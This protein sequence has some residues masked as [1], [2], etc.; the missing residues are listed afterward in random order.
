M[1]FLES[2]ED[3]GIVREIGL[4]QVLGAPL[5]LKR[6]LMLGVGSVATVQRRLQRLKRRGVVLE[7]RSDDDRR[8]IELTLSPSCMRTFGKYEA[9]LAES[10]TDPAEGKPQRRALGRHLCVLC[11]GEPSCREL[12]KRASGGA[13][14]D[15]GGARSPQAMLEFFRP[16]FEEARAAGKTI[17]IVGNMTWSQRKM[18]FDTLME[19]EARVDPLLRQFRTQAM[20]QY[21]VRHF[22]GP[23]L[24]RA[25]RCHS[26]TSR[27]PL[28]LG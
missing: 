22:R 11:D 18:D 13:V 26:D 21:D 12:G 8:L 16:L 19:F 15:F 17:R 28:M 5:T 7:S 23:E 10:Q 9:L 3:E 4:H 25:L 20:C 2:L 27:Y 14:I 1:P 24:L 6:L